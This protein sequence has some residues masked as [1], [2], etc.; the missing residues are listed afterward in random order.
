MQ[1]SVLFAAVA[2]LLFGHIYPAAITLP[3]T[4]QST[5]RDTP[6]ATTGYGE[7]EQTTQD[8]PAATTGYEEVEQTTQ[9]TP[10]ATTGHEE[11]EAQEQTTQATPAAATAAPCHNVL[12]VDS[13]NPTLGDIPIAQ[14]HILDIINRNRKLLQLLVP[15]NLLLFFIMQTFH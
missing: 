4:T 8:T 6:A 3:V 12:K 5:T 11:V 9:D 14:D 15:K 2:F 1:R 13:S 10:V 7:V